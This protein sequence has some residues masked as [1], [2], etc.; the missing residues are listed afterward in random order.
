[1]CVARP[2]RVAWIGTVSELSVPAGA[3]YLDDQDGGEVA[4]DLVMVP[5]AQVGDH[6]IIHSGY[7]I[8]VV[9]RAQ[10]S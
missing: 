6:V 7:A 4:V 2:A 1:M 10:S 9:D 3:L 8:R 5:D